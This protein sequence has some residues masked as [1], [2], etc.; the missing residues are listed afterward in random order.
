MAEP[1]AIRGRS[2][3][4]RVVRYRLRPLGRYGGKFA[5]DGSRAPE[6]PPWRVVAVSWIGALVA[7]AALGGLAEA[8]RTPLMMAPLGA[9]AVLL[10]AHP[11]STLA[12]PRNVVGGNLL[13]GAIGFAVGLWLGDGWLA[14][15][16]AVATTIAATKSL[17]CVHPP[18]G[19]T[20]IVGM[21]ALADWR[22]LAL[23]VLAGSALLVLLAAAY[24]NVIEH[25][26]Y[27]RHWW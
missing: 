11:D 6:R 10:F 18:A 5:G 15:A 24:N 12:Q 4:W 17:R 26:R 1:A 13:G 27:P 8:S 7:L 25:R 3:P 9:S 22:F 14:M 20:A 21:H 19:A 2:R 16:L 23:P